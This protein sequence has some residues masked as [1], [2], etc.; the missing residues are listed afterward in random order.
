VDVSRAP[1]IDASK[2]IV[3]AA[4]GDMQAVVTQAQA[5]VSQSAVSVQTGVQAAATELGLGGVEKTPVAQE[6]AIAEI[7]AGID[8]GGASLG[9][10]ALGTE[11]Q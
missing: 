5:A 9:D 8:A 2:E 7:P 3:P 4:T 10:G 11:T 1:T 6:P